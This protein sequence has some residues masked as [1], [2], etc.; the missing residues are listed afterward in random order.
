MGLR[1]HQR[2]RQREQPG[3]EESGN[4]YLLGYEPARRDNRRH[5][6]EVRVKQP[7]VTVRSHRTRG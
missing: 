6:I 5:T 3:V 7:D 1:Q 4:Y 2:L